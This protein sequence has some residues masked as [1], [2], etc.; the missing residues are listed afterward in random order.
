MPLRRPRFPN[1]RDPH[2]AT[3]TLACLAASLLLV[4]AA[5][6]LW[7]P[8]EPEPPVVFD[9]TPVKLDPM[10]VL[11]IQPT[12]QPP[13]PAN[14]PPPPPEL[15]DPDLPPIE[16]EDVVDVEELEVSP[17]DID[18]TSPEAR[19]A[20]PGPVAPVPSSGPQR[21]AAASGPGRSP[22]AS[23]PR[24][25]REPDQTPRYRFTP[26]PD[27]PEAARRAG[28]RARVVVEVLVTEGGRGGDA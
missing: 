20:Q 2:V 4:L 10:E 12:T 19:V 5:V 28:V 13:P 7:P 23:G 17:F 25:V 14:L 11:D 3:R 26:L 6:T 1:E 16:V 8:R 27:Y 15:S 18:I 24:L 21:P 9:V 22:A